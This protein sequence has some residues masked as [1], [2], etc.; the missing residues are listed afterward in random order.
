LK[1]AGRDRRDG[2][3]GWGGK[4]NCLLPVPSF[5]L[6]SA[7]WDLRSRSAAKNGWVCCNTAWVQQCCNAVAISAVLHSSIRMPYSRPESIYS[8]T[9]EQTTGKGLS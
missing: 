3:K 2:R 1:F 6:C 4:L 8:T 9:T 5:I 7:Y